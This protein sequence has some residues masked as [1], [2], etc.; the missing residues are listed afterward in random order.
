MVQNEIRKSDSEKKLGNVDT[1]VTMTR[2]TST[3]GI[4]LNL[5]RIAVLNDDVRTQQYLIDHN[6]IPRPDL[7]TKVAQEFL[8]SASFLRKGM[9]P[10]RVATIM[11]NASGI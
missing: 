8:Q 5:P 9:L 3:S 10:F 2:S 4:D 1:A 11:K 7:S 6:F